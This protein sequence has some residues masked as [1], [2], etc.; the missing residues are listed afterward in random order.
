M[1][2]FALISIGISFLLLLQ[3]CTGK[4]SSIACSLGNGPDVTISGTISFDRVPLN[5]SA[6]LDF[7]A[8]T[9]QPAREVV[10]EA[11]CNSRIASTVT[12]A[13]G[14]YTLTVPANTR[15]LFIRARAEMVK[16]GSPAWNVAVSDVRSSSELIY[17][18]DGGLFDV[19]GSNHTRN[20]HA[21][22]GWTGSDYTEPRVAAPFAILDTVYDAMQLV[23]AEAPGTQ[24]PALDLKWGPDNT[25]GTYYA[26]NTIT[27]L[28]QSSDSDEFDA[29]VIAHE[30]GH[31][32]QDAFSRDES[33]GGMHSL[34]RILDI[35]VAF[36]EGFGNAFSAMVTGDPLYKDSQS[37]SLR[38]GFTVDVESN[39]C[40]QSR[41]W[42]NECSVQSVLYDFYDP[43]N[44]DDFNLGFTPIY[45]VLTSELPQSDALT[46]LFSF[47]TPFKTQPGVIPTQ[48]DQ[49][50]LAGQSISPI[51]DDIGSNRTLNPGTFDQLP[52]Y[53][54][55][56]TTF[57]P[58]TVLCNIGEHGGYN[59]L[60]VYRFIQFE[61]PATSTYIFTAT[62]NP[63]E[64]NITDPDVYIYH[65]G[66]LIGYGESFDTDTESFTVV[67]EAGKVYVLALQEFR[68]Y[69]NPDYDPDAPNA[70]NQTC[71]TISR[72]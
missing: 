21:A 54:S 23:L 24:F 71:F 35:R 68:N 7:S 58:D 51:A 64:S 25:N 52:V 33:P 69:S 40:G 4:A 10:V 2:L 72:T 37:V 9:R 42:F 1:K 32:F 28:G 36:S 41:G 65:K 49:L 55:Y 18:M 43:L 13:S 66:K 48:V 63:L 29:H 8:T 17:T 67:L 12:D 11:V 19:G 38:T 53:V 26:S 50:L 56:G 61:V 70:D 57:P 59:G 62:K 6:A 47:I 34:S 22:S 45:T 27:V 16:T 39:L 14:H 46:S 44:D 15:K 60:G 5:S 31:Y 3:G 30:W 20:L